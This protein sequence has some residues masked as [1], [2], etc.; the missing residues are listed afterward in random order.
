MRTAK[1]ILEFTPVADVSISFREV[2]QQ[3][4]IICKI[5][6]RIELQRKLIPRNVNKHIINAFRLTL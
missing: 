3:E 4:T 5:H 2:Y 6:S 1:K